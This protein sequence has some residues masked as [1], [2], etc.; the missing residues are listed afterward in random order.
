M[1]QYRKTIF[2]AGYSAGGCGSA[3]ALAFAEKD[4]NAFATARDISKMAYLKENPQVTLSPLEITSL[5]SIA[6]AVQTVTVLT[7]GTRD[8]GEGERLHCLVNNA[9]VTFTTPVL[10]TDTDSAKKMSNTSV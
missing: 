3:L 6:D 8:G 4:L 5:S 2:I 1:K 9:A 7:Q 10:D